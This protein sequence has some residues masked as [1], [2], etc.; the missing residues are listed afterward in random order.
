M[1]ARY[2]SSNLGRFLSVDPVGGDI[3]SSQSWNRYAYVLNN[4]L[5]LI[6]PDGRQVRIDG[7]TAA[8]YMSHNEALR[9]LSQIPHDPANA[10]DPEL[11]QRI[12]DV[13]GYG[14]LV[15]GGAIITTYAAA[16]S[17]VFG[18]S[19]FS[20]YLSGGSGIPATA[21]GIAKFAGE[22]SISIQPRPLAAA[23]EVVRDP[24]APART[25][26]DIWTK[27]LRAAG[28]RHSDAQS[29]D[30]ERAGIEPFKDPEEGDTEAWKEAM[31]ASMALARASNRCKQS[32]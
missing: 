18:P 23:S 10:T 9:A 19:A 1:H 26:K 6:D 2:F 8:G 30:P 7:I 20:F 22:G 11:A 29:Q 5:V 4:P 28:V 17:L 21:A 15:A 32:P 31:K 25:A 14:S 16:T 3:G 12:N 27:A 24:G 13:V